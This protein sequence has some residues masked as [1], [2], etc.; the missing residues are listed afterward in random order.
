MPEANNAIIVLVTAASENEARKIAGIV[1]EE[2]LAA[3]CNLIEPVRSV[4]TWENKIHDDRECMMVIKSTQA[5]FPA[6]EKRIREIHS[7]QVPEIIAVPI[8]TGLPAYLD[9]LN[10]NVKKTD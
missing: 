10:Q 3:C 7:Y 4:Y 1:V 2:Q 5:A 8:I 9:W 6:L